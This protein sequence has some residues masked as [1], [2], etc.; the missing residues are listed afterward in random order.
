MTR[1]PLAATFA[2]LLA[3]HPSSHAATRDA[4]A[5]PH[6]R[7]ALDL[8]VVTGSKLSGDFGAKS[9][10][11]LEKLPQSV[12][13]VT[14]ADI[15][16]R[17]ARSI[18]DLLRTVPSANPGYS[19]VGS[20]QSFSLKVRGFLAD[21]MRNGLRQRYYEDI[22][23]SALSNIERVEILKG[24]SGVL[25]GQSAVGGIIS[26]IT[27][28]P[29]AEF[30]AEAALTVGNFDQKMFSADLTGEL[31]PGLTAR[32]TG[33]IERSGTFVDAQDLDR[34]NV[35]LSLRYAPTD[36][37][38]ANVV[39]EYIERETQRYG[40]QPIPGTVQSNGS[41]R[42]RRGLNLTEPA[43]DELTADAPLVQAWVDFRL[44]E[45]W[46]LTPRFQ[47]QE[48]NSEFLQIRLRAP[49]ADLVTINRNGRTGREDDA[50]TIAQL[51]LA[52]GFSTGPLAHR[53]LLGYEYD[54]ERS[55]FTQYNLSNVTPINVLAPVYGYETVA[56]ARTFSFDSNFDINGDALYL[57]DQIAVTDRWDVVG[58][59]RRSWME[60]LFSDVGG[61]V[62]DRSKVRSTIWQVGST[63]RL[64]DAWSVYAGYNTGF[65]VESTSGARAAD[66]RPLR[67]EESKQAEL[68][69][70]LNR[71]GLR[72]SV[73]L[74]QIERVNALTTDPLNPDFSVNVGEQRVRGIEVEFAWQASEALRIDAGY[75]YLDA[76][77]TRS[78][79]GDQG[80]GIGDVPKHSCTARGEYRLPVAGLT[81]R[82]GFN[83]VGNRLLVNGSD[84][85]LPAYLLADV[86]VGYRVDR[87]SLDLTVSNLFDRR[88]Y[89]ASGNAFAVI[90][91]DPRAVS[92][93]IGVKL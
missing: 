88:Y 11:P 13:I 38:A 35:A 20:Y 71:S 64:S 12:Q 31:A 10:I 58:A 39:A 3:A 91:G 82:G 90:P 61:P 62:L 33:E 25:Y 2:L 93:R 49:Q 16:E 78:N 36:R 19:R 75:A 50:Y 73:S 81:L 51:D 42:L 85:R 34:N 76:E 41:G 15:V 52:G 77:I 68:G 65:D 54:R 21:Q 80:L 44:G 29:R 4:A 28:Q 92:L 70:R 55:R 84:V 23:A 22:D 24:P 6:A 45:H 74:F 5:E 1:H 43:V 83:Y 63:Y 69:V 79:D 7:D 59:V 56:P 9:G 46:T 87:Y 40:G 66:G 27:K 48:F 57:Q 67:P 30:G 8:I 72:G 89:T 60:S 86:G 26:V 47:Y 14:A 17:G 53:V 32:L 18:G 37:V